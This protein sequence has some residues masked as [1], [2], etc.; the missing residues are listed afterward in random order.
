MLETGKKANRET[1]FDYDAIGKKRFGSEKTLRI[2]KNDLT[3][4]HL[5]GI[6]RREM[7][8]CCLISTVANGMERRLKDQPDLPAN[9]MGDC[10]K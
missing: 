5:S 9:D 8:N 10:E 6:I 4:R 7:E 3:C 2:P 1:E